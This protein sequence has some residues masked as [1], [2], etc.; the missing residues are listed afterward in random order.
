MP[1]THTPSAAG[2]GTVGALDRAIMIIDALA[3][4]PDGLDLPAIAAAVGMSP[5]GAHRTLKSLSLGGVVTQ[6]ARRGPYFLGPR[7]LVWAAEMRDEGA[8]VSIARPALVELNDATGESV[9]LSILR[10]AQIWNV[11]WLPGQGQV[12]TRPQQGY[13]TLFHA[14]GR[15]KLFLAHMP[16]ARARSIIQATGLPAH[17]PNTI[18]DEDALW[19][20]VDLV[21]ERGYATSRDESFAGGSGVA[22]PVLDERGDLLAIVAVS[23]PSVRFEELGEDYFLAPTRSAASQ[24]ARWWVS[25]A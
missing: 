1:E 5:S 13:E 24:I 23:V 18:V 12:V 20:E 14:T 15:G 11:A 22:V 4:A 21:R 3:G 10:G 9:V 17:G 7:I 16:P 2:A 25:G 8:L 6:R 19:A